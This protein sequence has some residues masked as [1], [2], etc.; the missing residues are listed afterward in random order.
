MRVLVDTSVWSLA[1]RK[2]GPAD[3]PAVRKLAHL[4]DSYEDLVLIGIIE[5]EI[6]QAFRSESMFRKV[7]RNLESFPILPLER[8]DY[9]AAA[10]LHRKCAS[11]GVTTSTADCLIAAASIRHGTLLLTADRDFEQIAR[12]STLKLA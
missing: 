3:H 10:R 8:A 2:G 9:V 5:Q 7:A 12:H 6:L 11:K 4:L 1:F